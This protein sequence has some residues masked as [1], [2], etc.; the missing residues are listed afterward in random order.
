MDA[1]CVSRLYLVIELKT[2]P[3]NQRLQLLERECGALVA[4][5]QLRRLSRVDCITPALITRASKVVTRV[6]RHVDSERL[7]ETVI[8]GV[9]KAQ[10]HAPLSR[11]LGAVDAGAFE[12]RKS[13]RLNSSH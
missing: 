12:D 5:D 11:L 9:L 7:L 4:H 8:D 1:S 13:T 2:P 6:G 10:G 3:Q